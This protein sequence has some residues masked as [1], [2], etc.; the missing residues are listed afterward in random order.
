VSWKKYFQVSLA[1]FFVDYG[2]IGVFFERMRDLSGI[3]FTKHFIESIFV[4]TNKLVVF[5]M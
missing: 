4:Q 2:N 5:Q 1:I 3:L